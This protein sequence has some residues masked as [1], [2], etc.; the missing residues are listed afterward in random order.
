MLVRWIRFQEIRKTNI[1]GTDFF[2]QQ[3]DG[4]TTVPGSCDLKRFVLRNTDTNY[5]FILQKFR[6]CSEFDY[7]LQ[8]C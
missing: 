4:V 6:N 7:T 3:F 2:F 5:F 8:L 1:Y